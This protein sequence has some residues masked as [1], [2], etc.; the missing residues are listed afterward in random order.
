M[1]EIS[2]PKRMAMASAVRTL[3]EVRESSF[4]MYA[5]DR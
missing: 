5:A 4:A 3:Q 1:S 2:V